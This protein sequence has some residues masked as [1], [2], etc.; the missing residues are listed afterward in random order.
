MHTKT[1]AITPPHE[2]QKSFVKGN[3]FILYDSV[4]N[5]IYMAIVMLTL[6]TDLNKN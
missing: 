6:N 2:K 1:E 5:N 3:I 4:V